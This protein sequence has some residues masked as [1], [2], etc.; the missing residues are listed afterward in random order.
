MNFSHGSLK[1]PIF[2]SANAIDLTFY[3]IRGH[4]MN[5]F[6]LAKIAA[7]SLALGSALVGTGLSTST[8]ASA[9]SMTAEEAAQAATRFDKGARKALVKKDAFK[10][11][12]LAEKAVSLM[13]Q[14]ANYRLTLGEAYL[15]AGRFASAETTFGDVLDL[16]PANARAALK[17]ALTKVALG[18]V[19]AARSI[20]EE[21]RGNFSPADYGLALALAGDIQ[22]AVSTLEASVRSGVSDARTRQNLA[23]AYALAGK[24]NEARVVAAQDLS[25][26]LIDGRMTQWAQLSRPQTSWDQVASLLGVKAIHDDGQPVALALNARPDVQQAAVSAMPVSEAAPVEVAV[27]EPAAP[28]EV[29]MADPAPAPQMAV[30]GSQVV[31]APRAEIVQPIPVSVA[32]VA[33]AVKVAKVARVAARTE[34]PLVRAQAKPIKTALAPSAPR[35]MVVAP[36][37]GKRIQAG[38]FVVQLGA[39]ASRSAAQAVWDKAA[40]KVAD[41][42]SH[43]AVVGSVSSNGKSLTRLAA[44]GFTSSAEALAVCGKIK[45]SGGEC[46]VRGAG[47]SAGNTQ[48]ASLVPAKRTQVASR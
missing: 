34:T 36:Q 11:V 43:D 41:L 6:N 14:D 7:S 38:Q 30:A 27:V 35:Q 2:Q 47:G 25:P 4:T 20:I 26:D 17:L 24:W 18:K 13:P 46:F 9:A 5:H 23:L 28:V 37:S 32:Q 10:A 29:A 39:F 3:G 8:I 15:A 21:N 19:D 12:K 22:G 31:F 16:S 1:L 44:A 42:G 40:S 45:A 33:P 48:W